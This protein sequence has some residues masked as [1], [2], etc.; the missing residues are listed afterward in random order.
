MKKNMYKLILL[1]IIIILVIIQLLWGEKVLDSDMAAE[2]ILAELLHEEGK[3]ALTTNWYYTTEIRI[4]YL[5][6]VMAPLFNLFSDWRI[7]RMLTNIAFYFA[8]LLSYY[9]MC[10]QLRINKKYIY[11]TAMGILIPT[12]SMYFNIMLHGS[13]YAPYVVTIFI[14]FGLY[15]HS[16]SL[17]ITKKK[18][19]V[20]I[21]LLFSIISFVSGL[22][23]I[24]FLMSLYLP[25]SITAFIMLLKSTSM[26]KC[27]D[28]FSCENLKNM[29]FSQEI[30][31]IYI[32]VYGTFL[33][34][35]GYL[36]NSFFLSGKYQ[37]YS[38]EE[39]TF[40]TITGGDLIER[41]QNTIGALLGCVGYIEN[42][43]IIST[44]GILVLIVILFIMCVVLVWK[45][46]IALYI[47]DCETSSHF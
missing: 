16:V 9:Y 19:F 5:Q 15:L 32:A 6:L 3:F 31:Y 36:Y 47:G 34:G 28:L 18:F 17:M 20:P 12:S 45:K 7:I 39:K 23:G 44:E 27:R 13:Y 30:Y 21:L 33:A 25:L 46:T 41:F 2:M 1:I 24:R 10:R 43:N 37:L 26:Q 11:L 35:V 8:M 29:L 38:Y 40:I 14:V 22:S 4:L 42:V